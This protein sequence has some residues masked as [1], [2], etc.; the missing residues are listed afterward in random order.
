VAPDL[1]LRD[2]SLD[3]RSRLIELQRRSSLIWEDQ[4]EQLLAHPEVF[5]VPVEQFAGGGVRVAERDG[6]VVGFAAVVRDAGAWELDGLFVEPDAMRGGVGSALVADVASRADAAG[7]REI[8]VV[9]QPGARAFYERAGFVA[10]GDT[11]TRFGPALQMV[12]H[13]VP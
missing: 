6:R 10:T 3:E 5:D 8:R 11:P 4:R 12:R 7:V 9:A 2:G 1:H 13:L